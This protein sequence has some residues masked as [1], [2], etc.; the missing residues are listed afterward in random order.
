MHIE[1][2]IEVSRNSDAIQEKVTALYYGARELLRPVDERTWSD[3]YS[4]VFERRQRASI[5]YRDLGENETAIEARIA[6]L[7]D[8]DTQQLQATRN[9]YRSQSREAQSKE[10]RLNARLESMQE[11]S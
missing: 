9:H 3:E 1:H 11:T 10:I 6:A 5:R 4:D 7:P 8:V 2:L